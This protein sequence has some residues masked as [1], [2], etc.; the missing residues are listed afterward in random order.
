MLFSSDIL[1]DFSEIC[2]SVRIV[3]TVNN[4]IEDKYFFDPSRQ[5]TIAIHQVGVNIY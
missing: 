2:S 3:D 5:I 4:V 1:F